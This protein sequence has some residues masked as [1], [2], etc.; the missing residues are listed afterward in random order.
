MYAERTRDFS[1]EAY[2][3]KNCVNCDNLHLDSRHAVA[4]ETD[5]R[6]SHT[7]RLRKFFQDFY[8]DPATLL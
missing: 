5:I 4:S 2:V 7:I 8:H 3:E 1:F 6:I